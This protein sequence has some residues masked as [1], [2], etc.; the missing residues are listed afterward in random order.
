MGN[1][2]LIACQDYEKDHVQKAVDDAVELLGGWQR[3]IHPGMRVV[4]KANLI[5]KKNPENHA[6][7]HPSVIQAI[8]KSIISLGAHPVIAD[9]PGGPFIP[10]MLKNVYNGT[11]MTEAAQNSGAELNWDTSSE[12]VDFPEGLR[13]KHL[14]IAKYV[15]TADAVITVGKLKTHGMTGYTGAVKNLFG[16]IPGAV[17]TE[18]HYQLPNVTDFSQILVDIANF[19][20][21]VL[22]FIDGIW[23][24]EGSGPTQGDPRKIGALI[25]GDCPHSA[26]IIGITLIGQNPM[27]ICTIQRAAEM[28]IVTGKLSDVHLLGDPV[29]SLIVKD[30]IPAT[31]H[32][33][34]VLRQVLPPFIDNA[35]GKMLQAKPMVNKRKCMACGDCMRSCPPK[36][37]KISNHYPLIDR[38]LCIHCF[39][40]QELC[41]HGA[42]EIK[43]SPLIR[44]FR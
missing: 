8:C 13:L 11:G 26:D 12:E 33:V 25:A 36:A 6:T 41:P 39:C 17:K 3:F 4:V 32:S 40:C 16:T 21:P 29:E 28:G 37:I 31:E 22:S 38:S 10:A 9:S 19:V 35:V 27:D 7:T 43:R 5:M 42:M 24:M 14:I 18:C 2:S 44:I 15:L 30:F 20:H 1:V 23:G 34:R